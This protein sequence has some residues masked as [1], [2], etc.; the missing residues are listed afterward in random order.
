MNGSKNARSKKF[1]MSRS[2]S[3]SNLFNERVR[4]K[5]KMLEITNLKRTSVIGL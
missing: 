4:A 5:R 3:G 2:L 1:F